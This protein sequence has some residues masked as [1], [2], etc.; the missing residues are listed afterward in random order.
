MKDMYMNQKEVTNASKE[1][2]H[3]R[4]SMDIAEQY[5]LQLEVFWS[6]I[7]IAKSNPDYSVEE[8]MNGACGE[9]DV[10]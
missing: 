2:E 8:I 10:V 6:A 1:M 5:G 9:W 7:Q 4:T 3:I